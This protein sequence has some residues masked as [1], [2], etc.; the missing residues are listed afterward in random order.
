MDSAEF[1][2]AHRQNVA[3]WE[4]ESGSAWLNTPNL[5]AAKEVDEAEAAAQVQPQAE[6]QTCPTPC[7]S[8]HG[9]TAGSDTHVPSELH[10]SPSTAGS[11]AGEQAEGVLGEG[12]QGEGGSSWGPAASETYCLLSQGQGGS[13]HQQDDHQELRAALLSRALTQARLVSE[14]CYGPVTHAPECLVRSKL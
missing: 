9:A 14:S 10:A 8:S 7:S 6:T 3:Q 1:H 5:Y 12:Q 2:S 13:S 11:D 4:K